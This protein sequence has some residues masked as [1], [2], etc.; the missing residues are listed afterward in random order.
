MP[1]WSKLIAAWLREIVR[2][3]SSSLTDL[4][5]AGTSAEG[6]RPRSTP[7]S[8]ITCCPVC[9]LSSTYVCFGCFMV[10]A[11]ESTVPSQ[12][13]SSSS[14]T[15]ASPFATETS[16]ISWSSDSFCAASRSRVSKE[17]AALS[18]GSAVGCAITVTS[19]SYHPGSGGG[20]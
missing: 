13:I 19:S 17:S 15:A 8:T 16:C 2:V 3:G 4:A 7:I 5:P 18:T 1:S 14:E 12:S 10:K 9:S 11:S 20:G 6:L